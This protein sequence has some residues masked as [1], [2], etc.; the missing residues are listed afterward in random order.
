MG[1]Q[2]WL[3]KI[4]PEAIEKRV[5]PPKKE[6]PK[7]VP[8]S[9]VAK[10]VEEAQRQAIAEH[11]KITQPPEPR[12]VILPPI[13]TKTTVEVA[14]TTVTIPET[15]E[16]IYRE[17]TPTGYKIIEAVTPE[18]KV[19]LPTRPLKAGETVISQEAPSLYKSLTKAS[20]TIAKGTTAFLGAIELQP[21]EKPEAKY[22]PYTT[23]YWI[24]E[25]KVFPL[26]R[27]VTL[28]FG[29]PP[30]L[31][32]TSYKPLEAYKSDEFM[33]GLVGGLVTTPVAIAT[34][35]ILVG[36][37][38]IR[39]VE[40]TKEIIAG[41][42]E[43]FKLHPEYTGGEIV[44]TA[45]GLGLATVGV[46]KLIG[47]L[48][49]TYKVT[50][51]R[52]FKERGLKIGRKE[53]IVERKPIFD[54][55]KVREKPHVIIT[56][57]AQFIYGVKKVAVGKGAI[58]RY[59][60]IG[61]GSY[62]FGKGF[63]FEPIKTGIFVKEI[64]KVGKDLA[65]VQ[66]KKIVYFYGE[67]PS[68]I[69]KLGEPI[70]FLRPADITKTA[71]DFTPPPEVS[72]YFSRLI[73]GRKGQ[74]RGV[75]QTWGKRIGEP[76]IQV[77]IKEI[78]PIYHIPSLAKEYGFTPLELMPTPMTTIGLPIAIGKLKF[79]PAIATRFEFK[80]IQIEK[81]AEKLKPILEEKQL[82]KVTQR[83]FEDIA[84]IPKQAVGISTAQILEQ[85]R[86]LKLKQSLRERTVQ[87]L[88]EPQ[89]FPTP[90]LLIPPIYPKGMRLEL[91]KPVS[92]LPKIELMPK[93]FKITTGFEPVADILS[94][95][96]TEARRFEKGLHPRPTKKVWREWYGT[97]GLRIPTVQMFKTKRG[98]YG[99]KEK[100]IKWF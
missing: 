36:R 42:R 13:P 92:K 24:E 38:A 70:K 94:M 51:F 63:E 61:K 93:K 67:M 5:L 28:E 97:F 33:K 10:A 75:Q 71:W 49:P 52:G 32:V 19:T 73:F 58:S 72:P 76:Q 34:F 99:K 1:W 23:S 27:Q 77:G 29:K 96:I 80:E 18:Q 26:E 87:R 31:E 54:I 57:E 86:I 20:E 65:T 74:V 8:P 79:E 56:E 41:Y 37:M 84:S 90:K 88:F 69:L 15:R 6:E 83:V 81:E 43:A 46:S 9:E 82:L 53:V 14:Y 59:A 21:K 12:K 17:P 60:E 50:E 40:T 7:Y 62:T 98:R 85:P 11:K 48:K 44:G 25:K 100:E 78:K 66:A 2:N 64:S 45:A 16:E 30:T 3:R 95:T 4:L 68:D 39:P 89:R 55:Y 47:K 35:P 22:V 91:F